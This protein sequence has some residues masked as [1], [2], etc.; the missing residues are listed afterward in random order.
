MSHH[1]T[2]RSLA[3]AVIVAALAFALV[4]PSGSES[5]ADP[6]PATV[7]TTAGPPATREAT[8][9]DVARWEEAVHQAEV[10]RYTM[11]VLFARLEAH[12][13][14]VLWRAFVAHLRAEAAR[15]AY[16]HGLCGGDLPPC[17]VMWR[18]SRG[19][20]TARNPRSS[21]SG[22]WQ[23]LDSTWRGW[24]GYARS[25]LAPERVQDDFAR[26]LWNGGRGCS[27][28]SAC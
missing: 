3:G 25:Y 28:W 19:D 7:T 24:G 1:L 11:A 18:E 2:L 9:T 10:R 17:Y 4:C 12:R 14:A 26:W 20:I 8:A 22:K 15:K 16:P 21:A 27:H 13:R 5:G 23:V 6:Q